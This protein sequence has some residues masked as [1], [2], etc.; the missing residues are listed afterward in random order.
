[1]NSTQINFVSVH[2]QQY[3]F[4]DLKNIKKKKRIL[5]RSILSLYKS[6][7]L[8]FIFFFFFFHQMEK[9]Q[10]DKQNWRKY[11]ETDR[12]KP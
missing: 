10:T 9:T 6:N 3:V 12:Q 1:M 2:K 8:C 4:V 5:Q 7:S 11:W